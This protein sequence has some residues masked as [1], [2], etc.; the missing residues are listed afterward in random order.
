MAP[1]SAIATVAAGF[2]IGFEGFMRYAAR[3]GETMAPLAHETAGGPLSI[4]MGVSALSLPTFAL[5]TPLGLFSTYLFVSGIVRGAMVAAGSPGGDPI[6]TLADGVIE[7]IVRERARERAA[8]ERAALEGPEVADVLVAGAEAGLPEAEWVVIASRLKPG[9]ERGVF[10][11]TT[12]RW[13]RIGA[14]CDR[15]FPEGLRALYPLHSVAAVEIIRR[16]VYYDH[17]QLSALGAETVG[18]AS[19]APSS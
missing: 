2:L 11:V 12:D 6:L 3:V 8:A 4:G 5:L 14:A 13:W 1:F 17:P 18:P 16:S 10:V 7:P 9:W 15:R 19:Q